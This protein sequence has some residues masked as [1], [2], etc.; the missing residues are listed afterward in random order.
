MEPIGRVLAVQRQIAA[1]KGI[2]IL[3]ISIWEGV[4]DEEAPWTW[5]DT[6]ESPASMLLR[7]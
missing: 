5:G 7:L 3:S 6:G 1:A 2:R 4:G